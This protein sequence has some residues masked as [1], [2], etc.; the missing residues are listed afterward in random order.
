MPCE[1]WQTQALLYVTGP[2]GVKPEGS[3]A[4]YFSFFLVGLGFMARYF[5]FERIN[6]LYFFFFFL[7]K[8]FKD[9]K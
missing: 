9:I 3:W 5:S 1:L 6:L 4:R 7:K 8:Y 2:E